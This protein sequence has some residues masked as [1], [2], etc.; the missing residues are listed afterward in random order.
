MADV[1][2]NVPAWQSASAGSTQLRTRVAAA[3]VGSGVGQQHRR[4][5]A[6]R[7][8]LLVSAQTV[9]AE[10]SA[11][12]SNKGLH[13]PHCTHHERAAAARWSGGEA[14]GEDETAADAAGTPA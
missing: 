13:Q 4:E 6:G 5:G 2:T 1:R 12:K 8:L 14:A 9:G 3:V 11:S 7:G 10:Q